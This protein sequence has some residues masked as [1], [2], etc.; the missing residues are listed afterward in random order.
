[1]QHI[2]EVACYNS[3]TRRTGGDASATLLHSSPPGVVA[4][5]CTTRHIWMKRLSQWN[6]P[7]RAFAERFLPEKEPVTSRRLH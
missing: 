1:M 2:V 5:V 4:A 6:H 3:I 7:M